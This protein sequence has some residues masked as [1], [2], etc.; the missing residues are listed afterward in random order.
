MRI[1]VISLLIVASSAV[2]AE[3]TQQPTSAPQPAYSHPAIPKQN[4]NRPFSAF[5]GKVVKNKV[6]LRLQPSLDSPIIRE[7]NANDL[8][9]VVGETEE[10]YAVAPPTDLK[11]Y[12]FRTFVLDGIVEGN[13]VNVRLE[14]DLEAPVI[15][16]LNSGDPVIGHVSPV[17]KK[18]IEMDPPS[19]ARFY[20]SKEY[21][22]KIGDPTLLTTLQRR[23]SDIDAI[24]TSAAHNSQIELQKPIDQMKLDPIIQDLNRVVSYSNDFPEEAA[25]AKQLLSTIQDTYL[26]KKLADMEA[27]MAAAPVAMQNLSKTTPEDNQDSDS[28][29]ASLPNSSKMAAWI[30]AEQ[31]LYEAWAA[32]QATPSLEAFYQAQGQNTVTL[33]GI[34]EP[35]SRAVKNKPG[36]FVLVNQTNHLPIAY[37]YSTRI[38][39]HDKV[40]YPVSIR[41]IPRDNHNFAF[42]AYFVLTVD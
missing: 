10:F 16:Q 30:A 8:V 34:L 24:L 18:W 40:G 17:D 29:P 9:L 21:L 4:T 35:Y 3:D 19:S 38:N 26:R 14:P 7:L 23:Q 25:K 22:T 33:Q 27:K 42:P 32:H 28:D 37:L 41:G 11:A 15:A 13:H 2:F 31:H 5:T 36:D 6:R 20:V 39:L 12:I 1:A